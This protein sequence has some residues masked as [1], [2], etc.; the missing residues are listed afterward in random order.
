[1]PIVKKEEWTGRP[2][3]TACIIFGYKPPKN[4]KE[5]LIKQEDEGYQV[6]LKSWMY[7][8]EPELKKQKWQEVKKYWE[9]RRLELGFKD[10]EE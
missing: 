2:L 4:W 7:E 3:T 10:K 8:K 9:K 6:L 5:N 1:M